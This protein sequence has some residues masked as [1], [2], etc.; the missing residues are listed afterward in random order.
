M[1]LL[2]ASFSALAPDPAPA[3]L[4][5]ASKLLESGGG[6]T[7]GT[8]A[9]ELTPFSSPAA[10]STQRSEQVM[11][12]LV[13][14]Y[15]KQVKN[16]A[17]IDGDWSVEMYGARYFYAD[18][19][20]LPQSLRSSA[21]SYAPQ[22]F[23]NYPKKQPQWKTPG[24]QEGER[25]AQAAKQRRTAQSARRA[26]H[27]YN[28]LWKVHNRAEAWEQ[29]KTIKFLGREILVHRAILEEL[30]LIEQKINKEA[31]VNSQVKEWLDK[32]NSISA[33][34]WRNIA[35]TQSTSN[36][37]YGIAVDI[38]PASTRNL[39]TYWLWTAQ[40]VENW[41]SV[42]YSSRYQ[43]PDAVIRIFES[44][45]FIW[46]GKWAFYDTMHFEYRPEILILNG[47]EISGEY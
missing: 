22:P 2:T 6:A 28:D 12:S 40:K 3:P 43:P 9:A 35:D 30:A 7:S 31:R 36:H 20:L 13:K 39:E 33:W 47:I 5:G 41:W 4:D 29:V 19:R 21:A 11:R 42:P 17:Y 34:N 25:L 44:Y 15:P 27:F 26:Q 38:L 1:F 46:G 18:G 8:G 23:Y 32:I 45:G 10:N 37:A 16:A 24:K 14:A